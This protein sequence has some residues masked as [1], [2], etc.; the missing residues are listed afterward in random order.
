MSSEPARILSK[1]GS[2][3]VTDEFYNTLIAAIGAILSLVGIVLLLT[4]SLQNGKPRHIVAFLV[5]GATL[6]N[7][8]VASALHHGINGSKQTEHLLRQ[9]DYYAIFFM[10]AGT[11]TP[12]CLIVLRN[13]LGYSVLGLVWLLAIVG[14][15]LKA[16][17]P[18]LP[19]W[20]LAI[21]YLGMGWL[22]LLVAWPIYQR[23]PHGVIL[24]ILGGLFFSIGA[25]IYYLERP[26]PIPGR[27]GFHEIWHLFVLAGSGSHF[28]LMYFYILPLPS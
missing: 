22:G 16:K 14:V 24:L 11:F 26:N 3:Y 23:I 13:S 18:G 20:V 1:D 8:F 25:I 28:A 15:V 17:F 4:S 10:I 9:L 12:F 19:K 6:L 21:F 27:F 5:Y 7:L 2:V